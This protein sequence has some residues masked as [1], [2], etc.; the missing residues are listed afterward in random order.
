MN[1]TLFA[2]LALPTVALASGEGGASNPF[3]GDI[4]NALWTLIIFGCVVVVLGKFAWG[5]ILSALQKREEFIR[6][7]LAQAKKDREDAE[8]QMKE[9]TEKLVSARAE[10][11]AI[12]DEGRRDA[13]ALKHKIEDIAKGEAQASLDR[14]KREIEIAKD[15]AVKEL[16]G[17][18]AKLATDVASKI[19][20]KELNAAEHER[21]VEESIAEL[22]KAG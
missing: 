16:Y 9:Y 22:E 11:T 1:K 5:P 18:S 13:E 3:A 6:D 19:I 2:L 20:R 15:T 8:R 14:A 17:L 12:V 7:S 4:G 21:L 10:A